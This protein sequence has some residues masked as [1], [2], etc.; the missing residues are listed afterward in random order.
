MVKSTLVLVGVSVLTLAGCSHSRQT[1]GRDELR[2]QITSAKSLAAEGAMFVDYM[3]QGRAT[4]HYADGHLEFLIREL[5]DST[6]KLRDVAPVQGGDD[7]LR[8][9]RVQVNALEGELQNVRRMPDNQPTLA[10]AKV[11]LEQI[12]RVLDQANDSP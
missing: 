9:L 3:R 8:T 5:A 10:Q 1:V 12:Q 4:R 11:H 7:A 2:S 6:T